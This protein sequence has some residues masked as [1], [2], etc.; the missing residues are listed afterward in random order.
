MLRSSSVRVAATREKPESLDLMPERKAAEFRPQT[1]D[2]CGM[3]YCRKRPIG[4]QL[5]GAAQQI[6]AMC[7]PLAATLRHRFDK[8]FACQM[9]DMMA[10][11]GHN[12]A[13]PRHPRRP[14]SVDPSNISHSSGHSMM[15]ARS[16]TTDNTHN[17]T[18]PPLSCFASCFFSASKTKM[19]D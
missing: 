10:S 11:D 13:T 5:T 16:S 9:T 17:D 8:S 14:L 6:R 7:C 1:K 19:F 15:R 4:F 3:S 18:H 2:R 12:L